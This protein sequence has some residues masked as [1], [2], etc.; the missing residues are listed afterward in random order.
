M[1]GRTSFQDDELNRRHIMRLWLRNDRLAWSLPPDLQIALERT[2]G[3]NEDLKD[4]WLVEPP[5]RKHI[6]P[7]LRHRASCE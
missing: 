7:L 2:F 1:H 6:A 3:V 5:P 4:L